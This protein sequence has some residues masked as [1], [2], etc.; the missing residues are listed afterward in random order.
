M[1]AS[2]RQAGLPVGGGA[3][4]VVLVGGGGRVG[5]VVGK[6]GSVGDALDATGSPSMVV[7]QPA[8]QQG[9]GQQKPN[10]EADFR[11]VHMRPGYASMPR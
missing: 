3:D 9:R 7:E 2:S 5:L 11:P 1:A 4:G 10:G 6:L 8:S